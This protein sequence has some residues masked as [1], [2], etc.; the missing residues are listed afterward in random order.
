M[1]GWVVDA[2]S[3]VWIFLTASAFG[4]SASI[5]LAVIPA[6]I[7]PPSGLRPLDIS[8]FFLFLVASTCLTYVAQQGSR[9]NWF[10]D[11]HITVLTLTG[12]VA[13]L[14]F[15][16]RQIVRPRPGSPVNPAVFNNQ[17]FCFGFMVSFVVGISLFGSSWLI[18]GFTLNVLGFTATEAG[19]LMIPGSVLFIAG[20]FLTAFLIGKCHIPSLATIPM[21]ILLVMAGVWMLSCSTS[22]SGGADMAA[23]LL[24][25]S[26]GL[27]FLSL[28]LPLYALGD[29]K[30]SLNVHGVALFSTFRQMGGLVGVALLQR[31]MDHLHAQNR[32][33]LASHLTEGG[34][35]LTERL[36]N[37]QSMLLIQ[38]I[39][40]EAAA[41]TAIALMK[42]AMETQVSVLAYNE[43]FFAL[44]LVFVAAAPLLA[45][46]KAWL[47]KHSGPH[48]APHD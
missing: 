8:G 21:G 16:I 9:W 48:V 1:Q 40:P 3:W 10:D 19:A 38:G 35:A 32:T 26:A 17:N 30:G 15:A 11:M 12:F 36:Q 33:I 2:L 7:L 23:G 47:A 44:A 45:P 37:L 29:L 24:V 46:F 5:V 39:E 25:R 42:R 27:G 6:G 34:T 14:L 20:I 28:A 4:A 22:D 13:I 41:N 31:Y 18:P 43:A